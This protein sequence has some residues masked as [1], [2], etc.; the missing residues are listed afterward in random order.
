[1]HSLPSTPSSSSSSTHPVALPS[2][3]W[4]EALRGLR[5][6]LPVMLG[7]V[8]FALVL[9]AQAAQ[10]G[11]SVAELALM[12]GLN[13]AGGS[14]FAAVRL[15]TSPPHLLLIVGMSLLI[16]CRHLLMGAALVPYLRHLQRRQALP[17]LFLM[18][19]E[20]WALALAHAGASACVLPGRSGRPV[21]QLGGVYDHRRGAGAGHRRHGAVRL[22]H[23]VHGRFPG[24]AEGHVERR[25]RQPAVAGQPGGVCLSAAAGRLACGDRRAGGPGRRRAH[26]GP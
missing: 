21:C 22:R 25:A 24:A 14:E 13:F 10:K 18:C 17:A 6:S 19:D 16:N 23:G 15:W 7:F 2:G 11:L 20:T 3:K 9:G 26:G 4:R 12:T 1:M 5:A 8:P